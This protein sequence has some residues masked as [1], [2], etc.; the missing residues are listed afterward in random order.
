MPKVKSEVLQYSVY[1]DG[2]LAYSTN[3]L[4]DAYAYANKQLCKYANDA[5]I[6]NNRVEEEVD[7]CGIY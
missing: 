7:S 4:N 1:I 2:E 3:N 5:T 6:W